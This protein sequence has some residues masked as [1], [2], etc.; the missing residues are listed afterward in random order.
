MIDWV[1]L[2]YFAKIIV[3]FLM[4]IPLLYLVMYFEDWRRQRKRRK[5][6]ERTMDMP[7]MKCKMCGGDPTKAKY[8]KVYVAQCTKCGYKVTHIE[9][10]AMVFRERVKLE[11][12]WNI[13][14]FIP[15]KPPKER[16][17]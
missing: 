17:F 6:L 12:A 9:E 14:Q 15:V 2:M 3:I 11:R 16:Y 4:S 7:L 5:M 13:D 10:T 8:G 1:A